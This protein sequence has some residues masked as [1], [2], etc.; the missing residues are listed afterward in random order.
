M[1]RRRYTYENSFDAHD[2]GTL[3]CRGTRQ[4]GTALGEFLCI[5]K[6]HRNGVTI[7]L[8]LQSPL[9][10]VEMSSIPSGEAKAGLRSRGV[11]KTI[12]AYVGSPINGVPV[13]FLDTPGVGDTDVTPM[14]VL[15]M[16]EQE[17]ITDEVH[18]SMD[19]IDGVVVTTPIPDGR[20][21]P[22]S[23]A[24]VAALSMIYTY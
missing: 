8:R 22:F 19:A 14:K 7:A 4:D 6:W 10:S 18:N 1:D 5:D 13:D 16:I 3:T 23:H 12:T 20:A 9:S 11:T 24:L 15:T 21:K 2:E 17:L